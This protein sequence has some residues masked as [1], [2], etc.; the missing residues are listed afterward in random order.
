MSAP[1]LALACGGK[2]A[3]ENGTKHVA[4][5]RS[6]REALP[7]HTRTLGHACATRRD[8][9]VKNAENSVPDATQPQRAAA[10]SVASCPPH[11]LAHVL[12]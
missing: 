7:P 8:R 1:T 5:S 10:S 3:N 9:G 12:T 6:H 4:R 11:G 2:R